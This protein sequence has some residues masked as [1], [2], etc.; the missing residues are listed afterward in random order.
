MGDF[1]VAREFDPVVRVRRQWNSPEIATYN[2]GDVSGVHWSAVSGGVFD[3]AP[4]PFLHAYVQCD[5]AIE[6]EV[7]HTGSHGP[8]PHSIKVA[9]VKKD[10]P[11]ALI[12]QLYSTA[13]PKPPRHKPALVTRVVEAIAASGATGLTRRKVRTEARTAAGV[14]LPGSFWTELRRQGVVTTRERHP[15]S[16]GRTREQYVLRMPRR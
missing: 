13:G 9:I 16:A 7:A 12:A 5:G 2:L 4:Q 3:H 10:N 1:D 6:G 14:R 8:C 15:D 11:A